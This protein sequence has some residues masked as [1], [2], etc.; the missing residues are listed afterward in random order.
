VRATAQAVSRGVQVEE[1]NGL[2]GFV[3][4]RD[5]HAKVLLLEGIQ[6]ALAYVGSANFTGHGWGFLDGAVAN[7]EA[8]LITLG[9]VRADR[10]KSLVPE[11]VGAPIPLTK[12]NI[13]ALAQPEGSSQDPPWPE[14]IR[15]VLLS[16]VRRDD[17]RLELVVKVE[18]ES[19]RIAWSV[20]LL[21]IDEKKDEVL[22][23][24][25]CS[26]SQSRYAVPLSP[27]TLNRLLIDQEVCICW[28][29]C[30]DGRAV[31]IN[32]DSSARDR[33]PIAPNQ[34][35][36][37][38]HMICYYQGKITWE[39][40]FPEPGAEAG[41]HSPTLLPA[42]PAGVDKS[43]IQSY[44]IREFVEALAGI[45]SELKASTNSERAMRMALHGPVSPVALA[46]LVV[47]TVRSGRRTPT[48]AGF[49]LVEILACLKTARSFDVPPK[50]Q[51]EW[52]RGLDDAA[53][54]ISGLLR[55]LVSK[56][57]AVFRHNHAF[58]RY[59]KAVLHRGWRSDR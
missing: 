29:G 17:N 19:S 12:D 49:Q 42:T 33:L 51:A 1:V 38:D 24:V 10:F 46:I 40:L 41:S 52:A 28:S 50:L 55:Q 30:P 3:A 18:P 6:R 8:G 20:K 32:V 53:V 54:K 37:E 4:S 31:P 2:Q 45:R 34:S 13:H 57:R 39:D 25:D 16:P 23:R 44:Q 36:D 9:Q 14:F 43:R 47:E 48:A 27:E 26:V 5:L 21:P 58:Y 59:E 56:N 35:I 7:V 15:Q 11:L 22:L